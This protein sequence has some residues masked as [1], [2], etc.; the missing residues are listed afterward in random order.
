LKAGGV[1][2]GVL[3]SMLPDEIRSQDPLLAAVAPYS[4]P[5]YDALLASAKTAIPSGVPRII[6][7]RILP[8]L[9]SL[10]YLHARLPKEVASIA[11]LHSMTIG[12]L[13]T[14]PGI[15]H[16][17]RAGIALGLC[18]RWGAE[19]ADR[20]EM[21][22][23]EDLAGELAYWSIY[24]GRIL[25]VLGVVYP[26]GKIH[27]E[28]VWFKLESGK[29]WGVAIRI[30]DHAMP[31]QKVVDGFGKRIKSILGKER[32]KGPKFNVRVEYVVA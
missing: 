13:A 32:W 24:C 28:K 2:E 16:D 27:Q 23:Y 15:T 7:T 3:F 22:R 21:S 10:S 9:I 6:L 19:I 1:R 14:A 4:P 8:A 18:A 26:T 25:S 20:N 12:Q 17:I 11:A 29:Q 31:V 5:S 30:A